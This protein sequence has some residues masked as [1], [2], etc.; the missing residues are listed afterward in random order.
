MAL[1]HEAG[2]AAWDAAAHPRAPAGGATGGQFAAGSGGAAPTNARPV[3]NGE[4][5]KR[6]SDLQSRLNALGFKPPL[7]VDGK[8]GPKTLAAVKAF[9]RSHDLKVD[10]LVGPKTTVALRSGKK[11]T[12]HAPAHTTAKTTPPGSIT[13]GQQAEIRQLVKDRKVPGPDAADATDPAAMKALSGSEAQALIKH[14]RTFPARTATRALAHEPLGKP[15]GPGLFHHKGMQLPA[16]IQHIARD[17]M[18]SRG[19][20]ESEAIA[21]AVS[22]CKKWAAGGEDV[23]PD[24]RAKAAAAVAEWERLRASAKA[25]RS[26]PV[27]GGYDEDGLDGSWDGDY[28]LPDLAGLGVA[29]FEAADG[30]AEPGASRAAR[31]GTGTR[32]AALK[33]KL[34]AKGVSDPGALAAHIGRKKFGREKFTA[35]ASA[36]RKKKGGSMSRA[37]LC[38]DYPLEDY[39]MVRTGDGD[40]TGRVVEAYMT[41]FGEPTVISD[42]QGDYEEEI[43]RSAFNK[44]IADL[45]R[46]R[47]GFAAAKVFYNHG[48]TIHGSPSD[49]YSMPVAVCE[50]IR[51]E[52]RGP[53]TRSRYLDTPLGNEVLEMWRSGAVTAQSFTGA[54]IRS[55]PELRR[56]QKYQPRIPGGPLPRVRRLELGLKEYGPTPFPAYQGAELVGVRMSP[57]GTWQAADDDEIEELEDEAL[58]PDEEAAPDGPPD[59]HPT[60]EHAHRLLVMRT[61]QMCREA[62]ISAL[63]GGWQR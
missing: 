19:M 41:V 28:D 42:R 29:D 31:L 16:Y 30:P 26:T 7:K 18:E 21:T 50:G 27:S 15:G 2:R 33:A 24:T 32:F 3:G 58:P 17:L 40:S 11:A 59:V 56:G 51:A 61:E 25:T 57:L 46:S 47:N 10:G 23:K 14:L 38:R 53:V 45:E 12:Q 1:T 63:K 37:E 48:M 52:S 20:P 13:A 5:G 22:M 43:D 39:H 44:R 36:A 60:R 8:F 49:R 62:G 55:S 4:S 54:I 6:V 34:A 35:L 9:K